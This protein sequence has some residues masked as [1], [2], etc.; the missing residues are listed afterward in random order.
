MNTFVYKIISSI[1]I[2]ITCMILYTMYF[3]STPWMRRECFFWAWGVGGGTD[4]H[5][6][7][8]NLLPCPRW[9]SDR[10][11]CR[12]KQS[13]FLPFLSHCGFSV[14]H[15]TDLTTSCSLRGFGYAN[16]CVHTLVT[17]L[18]HVEMIKWFKHKIY[19]FYFFNKNINL[20][21]QS[22]MML[23]FYNRFIFMLS[24]KLSSDLT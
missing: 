13:K 19:T 7:V 8:C 1:T 24:L 11:Q 3:S 22:E 4:E 18:P 20:T 17:S 16:T 12:L 21:G 15:M 9:L 6:S 10:W 23:V 2:S 14:S 5:Q